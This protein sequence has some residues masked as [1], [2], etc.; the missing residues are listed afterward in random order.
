MS[1]LP[2]YELIS[3]PWML[4]SLS[5]GVDGFR[6]RQATRVDSLFDSDLKIPSPFCYKLHN[7]FPAV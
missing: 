2:L 5:T 4:P 6:L 7:A 3:I 1:T